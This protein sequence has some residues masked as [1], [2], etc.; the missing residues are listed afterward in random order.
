M[1]DWGRSHET[2]L[3]E[4]MWKPSLRRI[5]FPV[6]W[7]SSPSW[8]AHVWQAVKA[9]NTISEEETTSLSRQTL[10]KMGSCFIFKTHFVIVEHILIAVSLPPIRLISWFIGKLRD[11][12]DFLNFAQLI[13]LASKG[14]ALFCQ[15]LRIVNIKI[16]NW[17]PRIMNLSC[18]INY[19]LYSLPLLICLHVLCCQL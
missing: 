4:N 12:L 3:C 1:S 15:S 17:W 6:A 10:K 14:A 11:W 13:F 16:R 2:E 5:S 7:K 19:F 18:A 9:E 8:E